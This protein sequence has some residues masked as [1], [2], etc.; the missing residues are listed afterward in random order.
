MTTCPMD[1]NIIPQGEKCDECGFNP[2]SSDKGREEEASPV[3]EAEYKIYIRAPL[4]VLRVRGRFAIRAKIV[5]GGREITVAD[6]P[7]K[8]N[9]NWALNP[10]AAILRRGYEESGGVCI[11]EPK[12][13]AVGTATVNAQIVDGDGNV[14]ASANRVIAVVESKT[15]RREQP[16]ATRDRRGGETPIEEEGRALLDELAGLVASTQGPP[17]PVQPPAPTPPPLPAQ[18]QAPA[19]PP[20]ESIAGPPAMRPTGGRRVD[21][22]AHPP[23][24]PGRETTSSAG[25]A[26]PYVEARAARARERLNEALDRQQVPAPPATP[27]QAPAAPAPQPVPAAHQQ[28]APPAPQLVACWSCRQPNPPANRFCN[29]CGVRVDQPP[30]RC[31]G[32]QRWNPPANRFC[33]G[34]GG[35]IQ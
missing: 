16:P 4:E 9:L 19:A 2:H 7:T 24:G 25:G 26:D 35:Q 29:G 6:L 28:W 34:C 21:R 30:I 17:P 15:P 14:R 31:P 13:D 32:C 33:N 10:D 27:A 18:P 23:S 22:R 3:D 20:R 5:R 11:L 8:W 12:Q 1:H